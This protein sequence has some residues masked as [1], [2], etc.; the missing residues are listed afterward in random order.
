MRRLLDR[1]RVSYEIEPTLVRGLDYCTR[2][3]FEFTRRELGAQSGRRRRALRP[4]DRAARRA[5]TPACGWAAGVERM[6]MAAGEFP[7]APR[8]SPICTSRSATVTPR[9]EAFGSPATR[10]AP[11]WPRSS[12]WRAGVEAP[13]RVR[14]PDRREVRGDRRRR[15]DDQPQGHGVRRAARARARGSDPDDPA[16]QPADVKHAPRPNPYRDT[17]CGQVTAERAGTETRVAG[18]VHRRRDHGG[19]IFI[20]LRDRSGLVQLVFHPDTA[21]RGPP[22]AHRLRSEDV[23]SVAGDG[24]AP[25]PRERQPEHRPPARS[26]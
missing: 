1:A 10:A 3:L 4:A 26:R 6:L 9:T 17:W 22:P 8:A 2:T 16:G 19:L 13:A 11:A 5:P 18:W 15:A 23:I 12:S 24:R 21:P 25:R 14:R 20:D 7:V